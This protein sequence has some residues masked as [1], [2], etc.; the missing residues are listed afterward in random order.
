MKADVVSIV[1]AAYELEGSTNDWLARLLEHAAPHLDRG[2]GL[3]GTLWRMGEGAIGSTRVTYRM[4]ERIWDALMTA[5][6]DHAPVAHRQA[7]TGLA[8]A[9]GLQRLGLDEG[10]PLPPEVQQV[11][12]TLL[13]PVGV[14][15]VLD[16][17]FPDPSGVVFLIAVPLPDSR[18]PTRREVATWSRVAS[19][20]AAGLR[21]RTVEHG[22]ACALDEADAVLSPSG[23]VQHASPQAHGRQAREAL[24]RAAR[25][26][27]RARSKDRADED[28]ALDAWQGLVAG[29]WS[30]VDHFD[31]DGRRYLVARRNDPNV[32]DP[33]ALTRR[34]RQVLAYTAMGHSLKLTAYALGLAIPTIALHRSRAMRKLGLRSVADVVR[35]FSGHHTTDSG[36]AS[37]NR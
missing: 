3:A 19:H 30:L 6:R 31:S 34:E 37:A 36:P 1:E 5:S 12:D 15:D 14:Q 9:T 13:S 18:R 28:E 27:D 10:A 7:A 35:I 33:R 23:S 16:V 32:R 26:I 24:R 17:S 20:I 29:R 2:F 25:A 21:L 4:D 8:F 11:H 22:S